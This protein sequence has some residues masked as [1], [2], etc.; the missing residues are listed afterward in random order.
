MGEGVAQCA[1]SPPTVR[2]TSSPIQVS[3]PR[4]RRG[5][6]YSL[7]SVL[8]LIA[9]AMLCVCRSL[10]AIAQSSGRDYNHV[11]P[12][13]G[14]SRRTGDG[15]RYRTPCTSELHTLLAALGAAQFEA[16]LT[17]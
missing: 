12:Q 8:P 15:Q 1:W 2:S 14:F 10:A 5:T 11:A 4:H 13:L 7:A 16:V 9:T 3:D 17:R 6:V